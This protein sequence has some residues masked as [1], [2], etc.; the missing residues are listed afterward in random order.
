MSWDA[1]LRQDGYQV[2]SPTTLN[3]LR[4]KEVQGNHV[5]R[6][7]GVEGHGRRREEGGKSPVSPQPPQGVHRAYMETPSWMANVVQARDPPTPAGD[8]VAAIA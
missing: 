1:C 8:H 4:H 3:P 2:R 6:L 7:C 5:E